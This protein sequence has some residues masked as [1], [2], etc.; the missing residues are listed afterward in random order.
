MQTMFDA[1]LAGRVAKAHYR[2]LLRQADGERRAR[3]REKRNGEKG[4]GLLGAFTLRKLAKH[5]EVAERH[6]HQLGQMIYCCYSELLD[7]GLSQGEA[8]ELTKSLI[9]RLD[10]NGQSRSPRAEFN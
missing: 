6:G 9:G 8:L 2:E 7:C 4:P 5:R 1:D 10:R 3:V